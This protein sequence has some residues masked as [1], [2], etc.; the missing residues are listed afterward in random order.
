MVGL[1]LPLVP[2]VVRDDEKS[3][4]SKRDRVSAM[5]SS[6]LALSEALKAK[7]W[8]AAMN[9][10]EQRRTIMLGSFEVP[11][12]NLRCPPPYCQNKNSTC[13]AAQ[14]WP[15]KWDVTTTGNNSLYVVGKAFWT[16]DHSPTNH[17]LSKMT[18]YPSAP[19]ASEETW[20]SGKGA[21]WGESRKLKPSQK[22]KN[23]RHQERSQEAWADVTGGL[24]QTF[25]V[26]VTTLTGTGNTTFE[27]L[28]CTRNIYIMYRVLPQ[29]RLEWS[30]NHANAAG[31]YSVAG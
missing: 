12:S 15:H 11:E 4:K 16:E 19:V 17:W 27:K 14:R 3:W 1:G 2:N 20:N 30:S 31:V 10:R 7:E 29:G 25:C 13:L 24:S 9:K 18:L 22:W 21:N 6:L 8:W 28:S 5:Q 23:S 26:D